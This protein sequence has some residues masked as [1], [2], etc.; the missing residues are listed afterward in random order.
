MADGRGTITVVETEIGFEQI[1]HRQIGDGLAIGHGPRFQA[2]PGG[3]QVPCDA[4]ITQPRFAHA[5]L[6]PQHIS[7]LS[8][9]CSLESVSSS[10]IAWALCR[11]AASGRY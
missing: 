9:L 7:F 4:F 2:G 6:A 1:N 8:G 10:A 11:R 3:W 5:G